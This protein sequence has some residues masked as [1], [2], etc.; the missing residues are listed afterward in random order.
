MNLILAHIFYGFDEL[1]KIKLIPL[2]EKHPVTVLN[3]IAQVY[4]FHLS[5]LSKVLITRGE[6]R[7]ILKALDW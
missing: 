2:K 4:L 7:T 5:S 1:F 6:D 3:L